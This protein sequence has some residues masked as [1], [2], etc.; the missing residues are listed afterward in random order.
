MSMK[1]YIPICASLA[2]ILTSSPLA[3]AETS[4]MCI[5]R[6]DGKLEV[7]LDNERS[8]VE[9]NGDVLETSFQSMGLT[10]P[11]GLKPDNSIFAF[12][13]TIGRILETANIT[14]TAAEREALLTSMI[15]TFRKSAFSHPTTQLSIPVEQRLGEATLTPAVLLDPVNGMVPVGLFNRLDQTPEDFSYCGEHRIV[16][17]MKNPPTGGRFLMIFEAILPNPAGKNASLNQK[18]VACR[19]VAEMWAGLTATNTPLDRASILSRFYYDGQINAQLTTKPVVHYEN[20]GGDARGQ[21]RGNLFINRIKWQLRE[22]ALKVSPLSGVPEYVAEPVKNSPLAQFFR[23]SIDDPRL[24][25]AAAEPERRRFQGEF[26][27]I[28][29]DNLMVEKQDDFKRVLASVPQFAGVQL[30]PEQIAITLIGLDSDNRYNSFQSVSQAT[31][32]GRLE[33]DPTLQAKGTHFKDMVK[34]LATGLQAGQPNPLEVDQIL[35]RAGAATCGGC[36]DFSNTR[37]VGKTTAGATLAWPGSLGFVH[38]DE[39]RNISDALLKDFLPTRAQLL[40]MQLCEDIPAPTSV[41]ASAPLILRSVQPEILGN[42]DFASK[43]QATPSLDRRLEIARSAQQQISEQREQDQKTPG[44][45]IV[46]RR[47]H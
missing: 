7:T 22:W 35:D 41:V 18:K 20:Y 31:N 11:D 46:R 33:D 42:L 8:L 45:F 2:F 37:S 24:D 25:K 13:R 19:S 28:Y 16:Y 5:K 21:I 34:I 6:P 40:R 26:L 14:N 32:Q 1:Q 47:P 12:A 30:T 15:R 17:A 10:P 36:H 38:N 23:D 4:P 9:K 39:T 27:S 44:A 29:L 3:L 43:L